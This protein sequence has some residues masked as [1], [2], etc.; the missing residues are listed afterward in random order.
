MLDLA[1]II[2]KTDQKL[3]FYYTGSI[4]KGLRFLPLPKERNKQ[5]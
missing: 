5:G 4:E 2:L 3:R 1:K